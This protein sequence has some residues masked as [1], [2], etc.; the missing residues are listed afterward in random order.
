MVCRQSSLPNQFGYVP[1]AERKIQ[2]PTY[3]AKDH[4]SFVMSP[5]EW[6]IRGDRHGLSFYRRGVTQISQRNPP[7]ASNYS[8]VLGH[9]IVVGFVWLTFADDGGAGEEATIREN[10]GSYVYQ[11]AALLCFLMFADN[12]LGRIEG[13]AAIGWLGLRSGWWVLI[14]ASAVLSVACQLLFWSSVFPPRNCR[15]W[16]E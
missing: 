5:M 13:T 10:T 1:I 16:D 15:N 11:V 4:F 3:A 9:N 8:V 6:V 14:V 2:I 12:L 7:V